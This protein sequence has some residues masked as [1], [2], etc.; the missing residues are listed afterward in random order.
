MGDLKGEQEF[1]GIGAAIQKKD[2][3]IMIQEVFKDTPAA[4]A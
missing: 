2:S 3:V 1:D 4:H